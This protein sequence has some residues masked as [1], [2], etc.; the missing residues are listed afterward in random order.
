MIPELGHFALILALLLALAAGHAAARRRRARHP[1]SG[2][3]SRGRSRAGQFLFVAFAFGCLAYSF[4][5]NDFSVLNVA[6]NSNSQLPL[7]YRFAATW[8]SHEGSMLLWVLML[9]VW[10]LAVVA[11]EPPP[12][13]RDG[14]ARARRDGARQRRLPAVHAAHVESVR[15][16][17]FRPPADG[18]DLNPLLQ[19]PGHGDPSA[20]ALHGLRR[21]LGR[22]RVRDR[23]AA[24]RPARRDV[25]A[26]VAAVDDARVELPHLRHHARQLVGVLRAGLGRLVVLGSGRE[27]VVHA[28]ARRHRAA[29]IRWRSPR[30]AARSRAGPCCSRSARSRCRCSAR[31]SCAPAC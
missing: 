28:V 1:A 26:L 5:T 20:D 14:R 6:T 2:W 16:R 9:A 27:R 8:G 23:R 30:S 7:Q 22:V 18:R 12:A 19:D 15:A 3:R 10:T 24:R 4:V 21:L 13:R 17:C 31:S 25:G 11:P 29:S